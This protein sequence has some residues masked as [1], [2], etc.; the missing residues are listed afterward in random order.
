MK[1]IN[2]YTFFQN[3]S[4]DEFHR[5]SKRLAEKLIDERPFTKI[6]AIARGGLVPASIIAREL[7]IRFV[8]TLCIASYEDHI[9]TDL[10][11]LKPLKDTSEHILVVDDLVDT[12]ATMEAA[13]QMLP[14]AHFAAVYAKPAGLSLVDTYTS[15]VTQNTW[16]RFPWDMELGFSKPLVD[17][18]SRE[19][20]A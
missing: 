13:R 18:L 15:Q 19:Q 4:W 9:R 16:I 12:G 6:V 14:R 3:A 7:N 17:R 1:S 8:D 2:H 10:R 11:I 20:C 5:D